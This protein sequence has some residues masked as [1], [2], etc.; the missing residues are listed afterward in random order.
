[1]TNLNDT[2]SYEHYRLL[3]HSLTHEH[4]QANSDRHALL[5]EKWIRDNEEG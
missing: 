1:M 4:A 5:I 2:E 3:I